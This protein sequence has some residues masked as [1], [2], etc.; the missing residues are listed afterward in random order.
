MKRILILG[1]CYVF[2]FIVIMA[3]DQDPWVGTWTSESYSD[4]DWEASKKTGSDGPMVYTNYKLVV[5]ITKSG[6]Q[7]KIR[8]KNIRPD[9]PNYSSYH[10]PFTIKRIAGNT[11]WLESY[12]KKDP[13]TVDYGNG[14]FIKSYSDITYY[15]KLTLNNGTLHYS[16]YKYHSI[17]YDRNMNY[18]GEE[19][20]NA[21][22][23]G[24]GTELDL[25]N[26][27]W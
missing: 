3:Q 18:I 5:R 9:D 15:Y 7:Y 13:F 16:F 12:V 27:D 2:N 17:D 1:M 25:F 4:I 6:D 14:P 10:R 23:F 11:M 20:Y 19:D 21:S 8:A 26:D 22:L 24:R